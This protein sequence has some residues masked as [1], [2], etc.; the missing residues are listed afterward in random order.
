MGNFEHGRLMDVQEDERGY[1][2]PQ[3]EEDT[4]GLWL[5]NFLSNL[6]SS[7]PGTEV[8]ENKSKKPDTEI[9]KIGCASI[10]KPKKI[11]ERRKK[12]E[13][14]RKKKEERRKKKEARRKE[15]KERRKKKEER[16]KK[17]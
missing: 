14:R 13:E 10:A 1:Y 15:N 3:Y 4:G 5:R 2:I 9:M 7:T 16:R 12:K 8:K 11:E 17:K 6:N